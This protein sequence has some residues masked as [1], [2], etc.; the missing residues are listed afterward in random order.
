MQEKAINLRNFPKIYLQTLWYVMPLFIGI[1]VNC[2][3]ILKFW[4]NEE[5]QDGVSN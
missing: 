2:G 1:L 4:E 5:I 3:G